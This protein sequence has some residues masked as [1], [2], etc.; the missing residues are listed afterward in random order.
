MEK[1]ILDYSYLDIL[2]DEFSVY[3]NNFVK[4]PQEFQFGF[5][6]IERYH[7]L[8]GSGT[9]QL[10]VLIDSLG[11]LVQK[12][13]GLFISSENKVF[14]LKLPIDERELKELILQE[15]MADST[16]CFPDETAFLYLDD[17]YDFVLIGFHK[18]VCSQVEAADFI[19]Q[20]KLLPV[21]TF[22]AEDSSDENVKGL[23]ILYGTEPKSYI[24]PSRG[25]GCCVAFFGDLFCPCFI[26]YILDLVQVHALN[27][28]L[29]V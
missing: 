5:C 21:A 22:F 3:E 4:D 14:G 7:D 27:K 17:E 24:E 6:G 12:A 28:R 20:F 2:G 10:K 18:K 8:D 29:I 23:Q 19:D 11:K 15:G 16:F 9:F 13:D 26:A 1:G 25:Y